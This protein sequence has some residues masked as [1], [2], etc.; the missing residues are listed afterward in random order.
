M[1]WWRFTR[2]TLSRGSNEWR[3]VSGDVRAQVFNDFAELISG[4]N[5]LLNAYRLLK[6][7]ETSVEEP[8]LQLADYVAYV[9]RR[10][11]KGQ[12]RHGAFNFGRAF[13]LFE[14]RI[15]RCPNSSAYHGCGL[16]VW[17]DRSWK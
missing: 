11:F 3:R 7:F 15:R 13:Q 2:S 5:F 8:P 9:V 16:K 1:A 17:E 12:L 6:A 10:V 14:G 4:L